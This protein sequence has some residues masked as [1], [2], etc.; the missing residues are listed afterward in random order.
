MND[1][2]KPPAPQGQPGSAIAPHPSHPPNQS[3]YA[4]PAPY[5]PYA[6]AQQ[7]PQYVPQP[8]NPPPAQPPQYQQLYQPP[9][10]LV[11]PRSTHLISTV[12]AP[13]GTGFAAMAMLSMKRALRLRI[14]PNEVLSDERTAMQAAVPPV[15]DEN[16]QAFLAWRRS[17]LFMAAMLMVPSA[18]LHAVERLD[19]DDG[20]PEGWKAVN[21]IAALVEIGFAVFLCTQVGKWTQWRTQSKRLAIGW[22]ISFLAPFLVFLYPLATSAN[23]SEL[24]GEGMPPEQMMQLRAAAGLAVGAQ[25]LLT[26][27]P[28]VISLL[29][30]MIRASIASK[31]LFPGSTAPGWTM[32]M[33]A[34]LYMIIFYIFVLLPYHMSGS[35]LVVIGMLLVLVA[36]ST[37][38]RAGLGLTKPMDDATARQATQKALGLWMLLLIAGIVCI[39]AGLWDFVKIAKVLTLGNFVLSIGANILILTLIAT[40]GIIAALNRARGTTVDEE[41]LA[42]QAESQ[43]AGFAG[44]TLFASAVSAQQP[45][46]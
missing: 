21:A 46:R 6:P 42:V 41:K 13:T 35:N 40:D 1:P 28:K 37:L 2:R 9:I 43:V 3:G 15:T 24:A 5:N 26:L 4:P 31:T 14:E 36:K 16:Q 7:Q 23:F 17:V 30:G 20:M 25:A 45:P 29:Q 34:P 44:K 22:A 32:V 10:A 8:V 27:A 11:A 39:T 18:L 33:A 19:F 38:I 12:N